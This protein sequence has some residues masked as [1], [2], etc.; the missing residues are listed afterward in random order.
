VKG[1]LENID[2]ET[3][4]SNTISHPVGFSHNVHVTIDER[5]IQGLPAVI[6]EAITKKGYH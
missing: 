1:I 2:I 4:S 5:G 6:R 3:V